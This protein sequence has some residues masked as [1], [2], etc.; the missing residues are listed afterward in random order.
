MLEDVKKKTCD[1]ALNK[2]ET[3]TPTGGSG[4][5]GELLNLS[6]FDLICGKDDN[7]CKVCINFNVILLQHPPFTK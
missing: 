1:V 6:G 5:D 3:Q 2:D 7:R 4:L